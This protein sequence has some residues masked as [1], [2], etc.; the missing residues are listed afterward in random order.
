MSSS[1]IVPTISFGEVDIFDQV[2]NPPDSLLRRLQTM[3]KKLTGISPLI[4]VGRGFFN[5][6]FGFVPY[7]RPIVQVGKC[8]AWLKD[9]RS[10]VLMRTGSLL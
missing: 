7:R 5:Y 6:T 9:F 1:S 2:D 3:V 10:W 4:P 8:S